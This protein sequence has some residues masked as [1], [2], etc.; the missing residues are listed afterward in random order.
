MHSDT[1]II[2]I[3]A[4]RAVTKMKE[5]NDSCTIKGTGRS[6][7][8]KMGK[9]IIWKQEASTQK[10]TNS[11]I[12]GGNSDKTLCTRIIKAIKDLGKLISS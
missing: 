4:S 7:K 5:K 10:R 6:R 11:Q 12:L 2:Y 1:S 8:G 3:N 9:Q